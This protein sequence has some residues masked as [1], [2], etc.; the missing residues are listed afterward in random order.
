MLLPE[1]IKV[2]KGRIEINNIDIT[3]QPEHIRA[4]TYRAGISGSDDRYGCRYDSG[5]KSCISIKKRS[6]KEP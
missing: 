2:D 5:R 6:E 4:K 1:T 3:G